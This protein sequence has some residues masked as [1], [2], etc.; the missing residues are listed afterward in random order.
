MSN[1]ILRLSA[2]AALRFHT[3]LNSPNCVFKIYQFLVWRRYRE[4]EGGSANTRR[5]F[6]DGTIITAPAATVLS[7]DLECCVNSTGLVYLLGC[8]LVTANLIAH[9]CIYL[10]WLDGCIF[11][12]TPAGG[13]LSTRLTM[14]FYFHGLI[15]EEMGAQ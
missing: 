7:L 12:P 3:L 5:F 13:C 11:G 9:P 1:I 10:P 2:R 15:N 6:L 8:Q 4:G 14:V